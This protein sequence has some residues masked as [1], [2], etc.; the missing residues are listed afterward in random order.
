MLAGS[1]EKSQPCRNHV[2]MPKVRE[3]IKR[4]QNDGWYLVGQVGSHR[5]YKHRVKDGKV[6]IAGKDNDDMDP[7]TYHNVLRQA[8]FK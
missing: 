8:G 6:T 3:V 5:Q 4:V 1:V 7:G 2:E